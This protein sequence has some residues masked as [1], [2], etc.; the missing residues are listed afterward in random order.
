[1]L[2]RLRAGEKGTTEDERL[3]GIS[4]SIGVSLSKLWE[5]M[6]DREAWCATLR[7]VAKTLI[8]LSDWTITDEA[9]HIFTYLLPILILSPVKYLLKSSAHFPVCLFLWIDKN[10][11]CSLDTVRNVSCVSFQLYNWFSDIVWGEDSLSHLPTEGCPTF[12]CIVY[13]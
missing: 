1:M 8:R 2:E 6:K 11:L 13:V 5:I 3:D 4:D 10:Y 7:G 12:P 9:E